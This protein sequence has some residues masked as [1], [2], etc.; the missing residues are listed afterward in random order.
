MVPEARYVLRS[1]LETVFLAAA[2]VQDPTFP[3]RYALCT[4]QHQHKIANVLLSLPDEYLP[5][6]KLDEKKIREK[7]S[8]FKSQLD[9]ADKFSFSVEATAKLAGL[10]GHYDTA[11]RLLSATSHALVTDLDMHAGLDERGDIARLL[12]GPTDK[13]V[14]DLLLMACEFLMIFLHHII[15]LFALKRYEEGYGA[16]WT[17]MKGLIE[18]AP[19]PAQ[20]S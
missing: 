16:L 18:K 7:A 3:Q 4:L 12:W 2:A 17:E 11:Y 5:D 1:M 15:D 9:A 14:V 8:E 10:S 19:K 6:E 13:Y 20:K